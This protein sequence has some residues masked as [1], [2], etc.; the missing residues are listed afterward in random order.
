MSR[1]ALARQAP[2]MPKRK[3]SRWGFLP[4]YLRGAR[5][6]MPKGEVA[7]GEIWR[8]AA[9]AE[10]AREE[11]VLFEEYQRLERRGCS[12]PSQ[13]ASRRQERL[14]RCGHH[15]RRAAWAGGSASSS[16][17]SSADAPSHGDTC[18]SARRCAAAAAARPRHRQPATGDR[19]CACDRWR[20][21]A[22]VSRRA[23]Y[24][25][26]APPLLTSTRLLGP[27]RHRCPLRPPAASCPAARRR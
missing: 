24:F 20:R 7:R 21:P 13:L 12:A 9:E 1:F 16:A 2:Y 5:G 22:F 23:R 8:A 15:R 14:S 4:Y 19:L 18:R 27:L 11:A 6:D 10:E 26:R 17:S 25:Y 3:R